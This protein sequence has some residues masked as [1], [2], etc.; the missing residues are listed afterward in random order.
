MSI[1]IT[2]NISWNAQYQYINQRDVAYFDSVTY[3]TVA[4]EVPSYQLVHTN[5]SVN[6][7]SNLSLFAAVQNIFNEDFIETV[8]FTSR[9]RNF[10]LGLN[11]KF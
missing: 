3:T 9:G 2:K 7:S 5:L 10:K 8:G 4:T 11:L 1:D 6:V